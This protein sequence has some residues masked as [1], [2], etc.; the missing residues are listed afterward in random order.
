MLGDRK[1]WILPL[2]GV[3]V[4]FMVGLTSVGSGTLIILGLFFLY[5]RWESKDLVGTDVFHAAVLVSAAAIA[6]YS[7]GNVNVP[8]MLS[9]LIGSI[10][11]V[12]VGSRLAVNV[13]GNALRVSLAGVLLL[14]GAKML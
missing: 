4:G 2:I 7:A 13:P 11:G 3:F 5:P 10:P 1:P 6:Q 14:S 9:L 8:M 12:V